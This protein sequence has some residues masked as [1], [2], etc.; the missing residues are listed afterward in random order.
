MA[1]LVE[2]PEQDLIENR[3]GLCIDEL[4]YEDE[5]DGC[6]DLRAHAVKELQSALMFYKAWRDMEY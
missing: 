6:A 2:M 4:E 3:I 5:N 1:S